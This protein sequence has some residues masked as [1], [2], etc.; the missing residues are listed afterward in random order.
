MR[1]GRKK[2][3]FFI[4][5]ACFFEVLTLQKFTTFAALGPLGLSTTSNVAF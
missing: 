3:A 4:E 2:Q 5:E 1:G